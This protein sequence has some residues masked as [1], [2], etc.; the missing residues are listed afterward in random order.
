MESIIYKILELRIPKDDDLKK[1]LNRISKI[2]H[3]YLHNK[4]FDNHHPVIKMYLEKNNS[5]NNDIQLNEL[6]KL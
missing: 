4:F 1:D 2:Y 5:M 6:V 3:S